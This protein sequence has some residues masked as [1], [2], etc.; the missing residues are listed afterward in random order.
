VA[1]VEHRHHSGDNEQHGDERDQHRGRRARP[2]HGPVGEP[3]HERERIGGQRLVAVVKR[4]AEM[5]GRGHQAADDGD[6]ADRR[7]Q[8]HELGA[9]LGAAAGVA[10]TG[11]HAGCAVGGS[12][13]VRC[14]GIG[15]MRHRRR[16]EVEVADELRE[17]GPGQR[18]RSPAP[19]PH[20]QFKAAPSS[21]RSG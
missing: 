1:Q 17:L 21:R 5:D 20:S 16:V 11:A 10:R 4:R 6:D 12:A 7:P 18:R 3:E 8:Q 2:R 13:D 15:R 9:V 14:E 19:L